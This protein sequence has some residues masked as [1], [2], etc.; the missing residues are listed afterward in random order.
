VRARKGCSNLVCVVVLIIDIIVKI[1][2]NCYVHFSEAVTSLYYL[3][4]EHLYTSCKD[5]GRHCVKLF[6]LYVYLLADAKEDLNLV[7]KQIVR[8][9]CVFVAIILELRELHNYVSIELVIARL[10]Q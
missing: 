2:L 6:F 1:G 7:I 8:I 5:I 3:N 4:I 10:A 9:T